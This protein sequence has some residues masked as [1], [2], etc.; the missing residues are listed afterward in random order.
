M[1]QI[2]PAPPQDSRDGHL[3]TRYCQFGKRF[4]DGFGWIAPV[5]NNRLGDAL[6]I[7]FVHEHLFLIEGDQVIK[8]IGYGEKGQRFSE[9]DYGKPLHSLEDLEKNGYWLIGR[10]Y[11]P[12]AAREALEGLDDGH[13]Y[14]FF[15]NQ[16]QDWADRLRRK[17]EKIEKARG[18]PRLCEKVSSGEDER[19]W[20]EKPPTVPG[21]AALAVLAIILGV[22][23]FVAPA[24][25]AHRSLWILA[26][27]LIASGVAD[28]VYA[29]HGRAWSQLLG[30][31][32]FAAMNF[33]AGA[34]LLMD[35]ALAANWAGGGFGIAVAVHG[36]ARLLV[37]LRSRPFV[38]Y[39][40]SL[41]EGLVLL[42]GALWLLSSARGN[43]D[44]ILG[45]IVGF[46]LLLGGASTL[47]FRWSTA[48]EERSQVGAQAGS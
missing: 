3:P 33:F 23:S 44:V 25:A 2:P 8:N 40:G 43:R 38:R 17:I 5:M 34:A 6:N 29:F 9:E 7:E 48:R 18:L 11:H 28:V 26:L 35:T 24:V 14:S 30:T 47:W 10:P 22:G 12:E 46:N 4:L 19:F 21:S 37:A 36:G 42:L 32:F 13:Y 39:L 20:K 15:S 31:C 41:V 45:I 1:S 27:F 16:C